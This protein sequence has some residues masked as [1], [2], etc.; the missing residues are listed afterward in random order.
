MDW[1]RGL[2]TDEFPPPVARV[3]DR[4]YVDGVRHGLVVVVESVDDG[5]V[6]GESNDMVAPTNLNAPL[7]IFHCRDKGI[8]DQVIGTGFL[9]ANVQSY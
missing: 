6:G 9:A 5:G 4:G 7:L 2:A 8:V 1:L 3:A